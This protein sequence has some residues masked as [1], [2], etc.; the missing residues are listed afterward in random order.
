MANFYTPVSTADFYETP[1]DKLKAIAYT[2][3]TFL[4]NFFP[5]MH[6]S[7]EY[8]L[9]E[10]RDVYSVKKLSNPLNDLSF[11]SLLPF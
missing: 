5:C 8:T 7:F 4:Y 11:S 2:I 1:A 3:E 9:L 10:E 6:C